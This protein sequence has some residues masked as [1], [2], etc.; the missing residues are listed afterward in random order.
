MVVNAAR[1]AEDPDT[2]D[3]AGD[4]RQTV[5]GAAYRT[6]RRQIMHDVRHELA[7]VGRAAEHGGQAARGLAI[8]RDFLDTCGGRM[9]IG[10]GG[11]GG[12][13]VRLRLSLPEVGTVGQAR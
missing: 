2:Y 5:T 12:G 7:T 1:R 9:R 10:P 11:Q 4:G 6:Y 8:V 3:G 13:L